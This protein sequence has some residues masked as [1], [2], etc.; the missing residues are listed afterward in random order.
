MSVMEWRYK[1]LL[2]GAF[3]FALV[4]SQPVFANPCSYTQTGYNS[5]NQILSRIT[6]IANDQGSLGSVMGACFGTW[7]GSTSC[8]GYVGQDCGAYGWF[9]SQAKGNV[10]RFYIYFHDFNPGPIA[11]G[12]LSASDTGTYAYTMIY[13]N[14]CNSANLPAVTSTSGGQCLDVPSKLAPASAK[15]NMSLP[16]N[17]LSVLGIAALAVLIISPNK[18]RNKPRE[19]SVKSG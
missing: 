18:K 1:T 16:W 6:V 10:T 11:T 2:L 14:L 5:N 13:S 4:F 8:T 15:P 17:G 12:G 19:A 3:V 9:G 7:D